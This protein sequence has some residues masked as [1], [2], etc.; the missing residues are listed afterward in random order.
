MNSLFEAEFT[1][2]KDQ[3]SRYPF[4]TFAPNPGTKGFPLLSGL[5][6]NF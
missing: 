2:S 3:L 5:D 4:Q 1:I 6:Q